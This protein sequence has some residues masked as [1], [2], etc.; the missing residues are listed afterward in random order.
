MHLEKAVSV[1]INPTAPQE[2][3]HQPLTRSWSYSPTLFV[4]VQQVQ[5]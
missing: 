5:T 4:N 3:L 1:W 2:Y